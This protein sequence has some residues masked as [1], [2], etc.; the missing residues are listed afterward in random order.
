LFDGNG[1]SLILNN[2]GTRL[3]N[4]HR[5]GSKPEVYIVMSETARLAQATNS[6]KFPT[7]DAATDLNQL[8]YLGAKIKHCHNEAVTH[9]SQALRKSRECGEFVAKARPIWNNLRAKGECKLKWEEWLLENAGISRNTANKYQRI[10]VNFD[11]LETL[12]PEQQ[13]IA[14]AL[15]YLGSL[16]VGTRNQRTIRIRTVTVKNADLIAAAAKHNI[17]NVID[18]TKLLA[19]INDV[20]KV[21]HIT[22]TIKIEEVSLHL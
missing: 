7:L 12:P 5:V 8:A 18:V 14:A 19:V 10:Y 3:G 11:K 20:L 4:V 21:A 2:A 9:Q 16:K 1:F 15:D 13:S 17:D 22:K 6:N